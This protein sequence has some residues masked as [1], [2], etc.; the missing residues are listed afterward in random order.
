[1]HTVD[2]VNAGS[3]IDSAKYVKVFRVGNKLSAVEIC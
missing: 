2:V 3:A 1:L